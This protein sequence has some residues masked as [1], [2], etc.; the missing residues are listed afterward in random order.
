MLVAAFQFHKGTIRTLQECSVTHDY[1]RF[2]S[3]K[4]RLERFSASLSCVYLQKF[5]F[6]KGTIRTA[7]AH[8]CTLCH[9]QF[10]FHK[11]T[12]RTQGL[13]ML[14][15]RRKGFNSIKVRLEHVCDPC[16]DYGDDG[17]NSIKVR[18]E[19][20]ADGWSYNPNVFQFHKGTI[21]TAVVFSLP[22]SVMSFNS[23]KVRLER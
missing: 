13:F 12:I 4:V 16:S 20:R 14:P 1:E 3:I 21:R 19:P 10:Q 9:A 8:G 11:G 2:N 7:H 17:F 18:L 6:H 15:T 5:Q 23:I 22:L